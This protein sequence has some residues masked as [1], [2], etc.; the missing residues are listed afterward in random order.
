MINYNNDF[1]YQFIKIY[2]VVNEDVCKSCIKTINKNKDWIQHT[3]YNESLKKS[4]TRSGSKELSV[5]HY[6]QASG[7]E[8]KIIMDAIWLALQKYFKDL[9][10]PWFSQWHG[11]TAIRFN[12]Y[13]KNKKMAFHCDHIHSIFEGPRRGIPFL[14]ILGSLNNNYEGGEFI[15]FDKKEYKIKAGQVLIFPS[16][17]FFPHRVEPVT[18]GTRYTY[19]S[20][21]Y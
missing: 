4:H 16:F 5:L 21:A 8:K 1:L 6:D 11:Y 20:W 18:K 7:D 3:F 12:R 13:K 14:S 9:D 17:F 2:D 15:M 19:I 10:T